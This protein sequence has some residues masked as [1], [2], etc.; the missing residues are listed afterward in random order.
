MSLGWSSTAEDVQRAIDA[1]A[2]IVAGAASSPVP[3]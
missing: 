1:V 2:H 3:T